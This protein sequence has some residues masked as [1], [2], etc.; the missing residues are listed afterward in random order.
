MNFENER[1]FCE[2]EVY[3]PHEHL[4]PTFS[5]LPSKPIEQKTEPKIGYKDNEMK[6]VKSPPYLSPLPPLPPPK[7]T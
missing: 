4:G 7:H 2:P 6:P 5:P 1:Y 3:Y